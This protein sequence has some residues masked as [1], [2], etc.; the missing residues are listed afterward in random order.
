MA[1]NEVVPGDGEHGF[2][3]SPRYT[4]WTRVALHAVVPSLLGFGK[5]KDLPAY[6]VACRDML[7]LWHPFTASMEV[8][9]VVSKTLGEKLRR[10]PPPGATMNT[11]GLLPRTC[12]QRWFCP[13]CWG[14]A[15]A[16]VW[17]PLDLLL[18]PQKKGEDIPASSA[19]EIVTLRQR[20]DL[21]VICESPGLHCVAPMAAIRVRA[22]AVKGGHKL[23]FGA[24]QAENRS[25]NAL[26]S[27]EFMSLDPPH[28]SKGWVVSINRIYVVERGIKFRRTGP[29]GPYTEIRSLP[30][31]AELADAVGL[32]FRYPEHLLTAAEMD[33]R[34]YLDMRAGFPTPEELANK[35]KTKGFRMMAKTGILRNKTEKAGD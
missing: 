4:L 21:G 20:H 33:V 13:F 9:G 23:P 31:R 2:D 25:T 8:A 28:E 35:K 5:I 14:R 3:L 26:G 34:L 22:G 30:S 17:H 27:F 19:Y 12:G 6:R 15:A 32:A 16:R 10:C 1:E 29:Q 7:S 24:R 18:F 11:L